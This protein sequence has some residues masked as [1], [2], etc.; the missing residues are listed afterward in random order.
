MNVL[1]LEALRLAWEKERFLV[2]A[3][4]LIKQQKPVWRITHGGRRPT[5]TSTRRVTAWGK[6]LPRVYSTGLLSIWCGRRV[7]TE[8]EV[9]QTLLLCAC[10]WCVAPGTL[11][12]GMRQVLVDCPGIPDKARVIPEGLFQTF[13]NGIAWHPLAGA[14]ETAILDSLCPA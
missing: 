1:D 9:R 12:S 2:Q 3:K 10:V 6:Q 11:H 7:E 8:D 13:L 5:T 4:R 14:G